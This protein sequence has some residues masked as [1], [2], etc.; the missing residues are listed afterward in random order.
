MALK[1][2]C[3]RAAGSQGKKNLALSSHSLR[4]EHNSLWQVIKLAAASLGMAET[5]VNGKALLLQL[6]LKFSRLNRPTCLVRKQYR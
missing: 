2:R 3:A 5:L 6:E 1:V 4:T